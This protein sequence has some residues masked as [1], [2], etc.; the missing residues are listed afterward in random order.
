MIHVF[1]KTDVFTDADK[2]ETNLPIHCAGI[3][4]ANV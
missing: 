1:A 3:F 2:C 4:P